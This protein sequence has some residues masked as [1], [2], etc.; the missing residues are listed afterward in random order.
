[1][2]FGAT[3]GPMTADQMNGVQGHVLHIPT[4]MGAVVLTYNL[5]SIGPPSSNSMAR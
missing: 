1:M 5:P 3:D 4:V 2:D